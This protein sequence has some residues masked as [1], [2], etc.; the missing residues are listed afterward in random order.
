MLQLMKINV[1]QVAVLIAVS[2]FRFKTTPM[3]QILSWRYPYIFAGFSFNLIHIL[4]DPA[5]I[6]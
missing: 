1:L 3:S 2:F 4:F 5:P 6:N